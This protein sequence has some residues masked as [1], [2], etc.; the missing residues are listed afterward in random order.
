MNYKEATPP[1]PAPVSLGEFRGRPVSVMTLGGEW[2]LVTRRERDALVELA[3]AYLAV[4]DLD[5]LPASEI[6]N[7]P[8]G[9]YRH[10]LDRLYAAAK[11]VRP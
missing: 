4:R 10:A 2:I 7:R 11:G 6:P 3:E 8:I 9:E 5:A 1:V